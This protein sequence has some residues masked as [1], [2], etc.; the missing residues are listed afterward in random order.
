MC[1]RDSCY[2]NGKLTTKFY[3]QPPP[4]CKRKAFWMS[5]VD[6]VSVSLQ[7][8]EPTNWMDGE[9]TR[10]WLMD[11]MGVLYNY[12]ED[13]FVTNCP[14]MRMSRSM[15]W[16]FHAKGDITTPDAVWAVDPLLKHRLQELLSK[17]FDFWLAGGKSLGLSLIHIS[18]PT[19][20][21]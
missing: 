20:P 9:H 5:V 2:E 17:I 18:E 12:E 14:G 4:Q 19:R 16:A 7:R 21:Y 6:E 11:K 3:G 8:A 15:P 1:I 13:R 10:G